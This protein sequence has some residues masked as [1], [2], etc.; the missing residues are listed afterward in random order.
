M[1]KISADC[2]FT[3]LC[4]YVLRAYI[5]ARL[6]PCALMAGFAKNINPYKIQNRQEYLIFKAGYK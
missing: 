1:K 5:P 6:C 2:Y 4:P 3:S